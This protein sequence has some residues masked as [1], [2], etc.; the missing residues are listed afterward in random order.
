M[1]LELGVYTTGCSIGIIRVTMNIRL[2]RG[3]IRVDIRVML[4]VA[5]ME[6]HGPPKPGGVGFRDYPFK[7]R[8]G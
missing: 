7:T 6:H 2:T 4:T 1:K 5:D 3:V 8:S